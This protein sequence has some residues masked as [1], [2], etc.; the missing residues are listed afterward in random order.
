MIQFRI[1][2]V[3]RDVADTMRFRMVWVKC[4]TSAECK[5]IRIAG[6]SDIDSWKAVLGSMCKSFH[7]PKM[8]MLLMPYQRVGMWRNEGEG[9]TTGGD[10]IGG[11]FE[12]NCLY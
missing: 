10:P 2:L 6:S 9:F 4:A 12:E 8:E 1:H 3:W 5:T 11:V 7:F